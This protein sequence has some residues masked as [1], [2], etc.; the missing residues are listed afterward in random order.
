MTITP[1]PQLSP[2]SS[3]REYPSL[4]VFDLETSGVDVHEDRIVT[5]FVGR[6]LRNGTVKGAYS[7]L[8]NPGVHI[9]DGAAAI[10]GITNERAQAEGQDPAT[11]ALEI[12][13]VL[14]RSI[15]A[16]RPITA[17]NAAF[18]LSMLNAEARR[19]GHEPID[20]SGVVVIDPLVIDKGVDRY[21]KGSR[22]L[23][24]T[25]KHL[26]VVLSEESAHDAEA[27]AVA[28]G[29]VAWALLDRMPPETTGAQ[30]TQ[31]QVTWAQ[32]QAAGLQ[33]Y[34]RRTKDPDIVIDGSWPV[35]APR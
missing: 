13:T 11:A 25:A 22:K 4:C 29:R 17:Y 23:V 19:Y 9:P 2:D 28:T 5:A 27:D 10:H 26:G 31:Q 3:L 24:D 6:V 7:W 33:D 21:R 35:R 8:V 1:T 12:L 14:R 18:D 16:G 30:L 20:F 32:M 34:F 15:A